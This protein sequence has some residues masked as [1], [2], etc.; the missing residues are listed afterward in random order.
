MAKIVAFISI[1]LDGV[2]QA[3]GPPDEDTRGGFEHGGWATRYANKR[4]LRQARCRGDGDD[5]RAAARAP[6]L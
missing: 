2:M 5:W 1:T 4:G 3:P 6:D